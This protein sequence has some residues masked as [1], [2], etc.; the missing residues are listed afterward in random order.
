MLPTFSDF[1][2][3]SS[4]PAVTAAT[5][6]LVRN[7]QAPASPS[8]PYPHPSPAWQRVAETRSASSPCKRAAHCG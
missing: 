7:H 5:R 4:T 2:P 6:A 1:A 3:S 8:P